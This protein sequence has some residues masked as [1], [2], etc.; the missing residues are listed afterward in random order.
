MDL[1]GE[2]KYLERPLIEGVIYTIEDDYVRISCPHTLF[3]ETRRVMPI[4]IDTVKNLYKD[5]LLLARQYSV[6]IS[7]ANHFKKQIDQGWAEYERSCEEVGALFSEIITQAKVVQERGIHIGS[8]DDTELDKLTAMQNKHNEVFWR[9]SIV[10]RFS[11][12]KRSMEQ[13]VQS[14]SNPDLG[15]Y[16]IYL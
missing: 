6:K 16:K 10:S 9:S 3:I 7:Y 14:L 12:I 13:N 2:D 1:H 4:D 8:I 5:V 15:C 11:Q